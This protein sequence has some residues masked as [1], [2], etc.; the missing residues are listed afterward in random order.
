MP[1]ARRIITTRLAERLRQISQTSLYH[2]IIH[3]VHYG[4]NGKSKAILCFPDNRECI[5]VNRCPLIQKNCRGYVTTATRENGDP[6]IGPVNVDSR[7]LSPRLFG[8]FFR[9]LLAGG[10]AHNAAAPLADIFHNPAELTP[11]R[12]FN[13]LR[14]AFPASHAADVRWILAKPASHAMVKPPE[15]RGQVI[16]S[17]RKFGVFRCARYTWALAIQGSWCFSA[18]HGSLHERYQ[19]KPPFVVGTV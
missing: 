10:F 18:T 1:S 17:A 14:P 7:S 2:I 12:V 5:A 11:Q 8:R 13:D 3:L 15:K 4:G 9:A 16:G 6:G 19:G